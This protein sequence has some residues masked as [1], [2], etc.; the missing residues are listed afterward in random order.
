M[1]ADHGSAPDHKGPGFRIIGFHLNRQFRLN[2]FFAVLDHGIHWRQLGQGIIQL[3]HITGFIAA[4]KAGAVQVKGHWTVGN[5]L[6][7]F[8]GQGYA[9]SFIHTPLH[10]ADRCFIF[11]FGLHPKIIAPGAARPYFDANSQ[12]HHPVI[13]CAQGHGRIRIRVFKHP[14][15]GFVGLVKPGPNPLPDTVRDDRR[16]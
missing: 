12:F 7:V 1:V 2:S 15:K 13:R 9:V 4:S 14:G 10:Q 5:H 11:V 8:V 3:N 16:F 6:Q